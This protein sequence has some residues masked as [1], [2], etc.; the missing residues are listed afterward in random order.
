MPSAASP[1]RAS[2]VSLWDLGGID[3]WQLIRNILREIMADDLFGQASALAFNFVLAL[4]PF[5]L[6]LLTLFGLF[7]SHSI[8]LQQNLLSYA[9]D[10]LPP[11]AYQLLNSVTQ[12][13]AGGASGGMLTFGAVGAL[14][15][16]SGGISSMIFGLNVAYRVN[17]KRSWLKIR[18]I[19]LALTLVLSLLLLSAL[20]TVLAGGRLVD[21]TAAFLHLQAG[22]TFVWKVL[23]WPAAV[24]VAIASFSLVYY[25]GPALERRRRH[26]I[27]PGSVCAGVLWLLASLGLRLY[28]HF[29][30]T[31]T[32]TYGS[33][34]AVM[35]LLVWLY[36]T[37]LVFLV[38]GEIDAEMERSRLAT[39]SALKG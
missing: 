26:W 31:Y 18:A 12:E 4:F 22:I 9:R 29:F 17:E 2:K 32:A 8:Q 5:L 33:L 30:N 20:L 10:F 24:L 3:R 39:G 28:L 11:T 38:G 19:A 37:G 15:F 16:A 13:L 6:F 1:A 21:W 25:F 36:V 23:Q 7:A 35:V 14:W 27:T 34:G